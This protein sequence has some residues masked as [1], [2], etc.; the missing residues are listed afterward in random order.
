MPKFK[1]AKTQTATW[2]SS[3]ISYYKM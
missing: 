2:K 1:F 3:T